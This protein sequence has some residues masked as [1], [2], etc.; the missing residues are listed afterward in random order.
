VTRPLRDLDLEV[1]PV[2]EFMRRCSLPVSAEMVQSTA[3]LVAWFTRRYP[4]ARERFAYIRR[5]RARML[6]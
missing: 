1:L 4:T 6:R 2:D 3:E 5:A